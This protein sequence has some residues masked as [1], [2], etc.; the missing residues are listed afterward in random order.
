[1]ENNKRIAD[2]IMAVLKWEDIT[3]MQHCST[4]LRITMK[5]GTKFPE[6]EITKISGVLGTKKS[7]DG[8]QIII[9]NT[10]SK[11]YEEIMKKHDMGN[12]TEDEK[13]SNEKVN[14]F[15][16]F[17]GAMSAIVGP[18]SPAIVASGLVSAL[19][20]ILGLL[21]V[22]SDSTTMTYLSSL[23]KVG[24]YFLPFILAYTSAMYFKVSPIMAIFAAGILMYPD[25]MTL[26]S[27]ETAVTLFGLPVYK[28]NYSNSLIPII[29]TVWALKYVTKLI[30]KLVP[31]AVRYVFNPLL[32]GRIMLPVAICV[33]GPV[34]GAI[35][36]LIANG[37]ALVYNTVPWLGAFLFSALAPLLV[38]TGSHLALLPL[39]FTNMATFGYDNFLMPAFIGMN[40]SQFAVAIAVF[41]R[42]KN[43]ELKQTASSCAVTAFFAGVT[44]P[45]LYGISLRLKKPLIA[46]FIGCIANGIVCA[47]FNVREFS[48]GAPSFFAMAN[49][50]D[51]AGSKNIIMAVLAAVITIIVTFAATWMLGFEEPKASK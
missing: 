40:F 20:S 41:L 29:L 24:L 13:P 39:V 28:V 25:V 46:T 43:P 8:Y 34:G 33:T 48:F 4:R 49:F 50:I 37:T 15:K 16:V 22:K 6:E 51:P 38:L 11:V 9:G 2:E 45:T 44:E 36:T 1:M 26:A 32:T 7:M 10:V 18:A 23:S 30:E 27:Q 42:A 5:D 12:E 35:G 47:L 21:G 14:I 3:K 19:I 31:A 17:M